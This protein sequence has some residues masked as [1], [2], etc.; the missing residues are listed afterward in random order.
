MCVCFWLMAAVHGPRM[1]DTAAYVC[2]FVVHMCVCV[3]MRR[4]FANFQRARNVQNK[5]PRRRQRRRKRQ[6]CRHA[7][8]ICFRNGLS[9]ECGMYAMIGAHNIRH[10]A[11]INSYRTFKIAMECPTMWRRARARQ[12]PNICR[13]ESSV[14]TT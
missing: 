10:T 13:I 11:S 4:C 2:M 1:P 14:D 6:Q 12:Q 9:T 7:Q 5:S 8:S 3:L